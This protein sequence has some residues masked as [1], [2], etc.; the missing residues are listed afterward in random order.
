MPFRDHSRGQAIQIGVVLLLG[1]L[2]IAFSL[3]QAVVV[4]DQNQSIEFSHNQEVQGEL[5]GVRN[6]FVSTTDG[7]RSTS[8]SVGLGTQY[9]SRLLALNPS[10]PSGVL[11][12]VGTDNESVNVAI[13]YAVADGETGDFWNGTNRTY[14]TG[15]VVYR[16]GYNEYSQAPAT[17]YENSVLYNRFP[18]SNL[19]LTGQRLIDENRIS[20][21]TVNGSFYAGQ[22]GT[23]SM[24]VRPVSASPTTVT[25]TNESNETLTISVPTWLS[26][27]RW[28]K[29]LGTE[30]NVVNYTLSPVA[31]AD[32]GL[33][34]VE[35]AG[36]V[37]YE[38]QLSR[39][40]VGTGVVRPSAAYLTDVSGNGSTVPE[41]GTTTVTVQVRDALDNPKTSVATVAGTRR[42]NSSVSPN[43]TT[44]DGEGKVTHTYEAPADVSG[45]SQVADTINVSIVP[46]L[47]PENASESDFD[48]RTAR[49]VSMQVLIDNTD[50]SGT[51][52]GSA[53]EINWSFPTIETEQGIEGCFASNNTCV[54]DLGKDANDKVDFAAGTDPSTSGVFVD[55]TLNNSLGTLNPSE[56]STDSGGD[57]STE[58]KNPSVGTTNLSALTTESNDVV[59]VRV[60]DSGGGPT[61]M[62]VEADSGRQTANVT[63]SEGVYT[64]AS[65]TGDL[66]ASDFDYFDNSSGGVSGI[67][68]VSHT[69]GDSKA[70]LTLDAGTTVGDIGTDEVA[71]R[72]N[73]IYDASGNAADTTPETLR[74]TRAPDD[75][76]AT[77]GSTIT[78]SNEGSYS[79][80]VELVDDHEAGDVEVRLTDGSTTAT[81]TKSVSAET[82]GDSST[83]TV[84]V[85]GIDT[86]SLSDGSVDIEARIT[87]Y[88]GNVNPSDYTATS[89]VTK[90]T[91]PP[92]VQ[93]DDPNGGETIAG[94]STYTI[95][96]TASDSETGVSGID[97]A[98]STNG[99][100]SYTTIVTGTTDDGTYDWSVPTVNTS[101]ALIRV[102]A[103]DSVGNTATDTSD[104]TF[105]IDSTSPQITSVAEPADAVYTDGETLGFDVTYDESVTVD[106]SGGTPEIT[107]DVDGDGDTEPATYVSGSGSDTLTFEYTVQTGDNDQDGIAFDSTSIALN[108]GTIRDSAGNDADTDFSG[109]APDL[110]GILV[111][112]APPASLTI[113]APSS[114]VTRQS[115]ETLDVTY[116]YDEA[117]PDSANITLA[118]GSGNNATFDVDDS[119]YA[120]DNSGKTVTL[121]LSS[122]DSTSG[123]GLVD[124]N[125]YDITVEATDVV[126]QSNS[127]T[128]TDRL[129]IDSGQ[130]TTT[131]ASSILPYTGGQRQ[132]VT[133]VPATDIPDGD[134][135]YIVLDDPQQKTPL[136]VNYAIDFTVKRGTTY[137]SNTNSNKYDGGDRAF[138]K[139]DFETGSGLPA[140]TP[141]E[142]RLND[143]NASTPAAQTDPYDVTINRTDRAD[144]ATNTT[145][146]V[147][148]SDGDSGLSSVSLTNI[149][150]GTTVDQTISFTPDR[151]IPSGGRVY[152][153]LSLAQN[154]SGSR[155]EYNNSNGINTVSFG[156]ASLTTT[157]DSAA[158]TYKADSGAVSAGTT[159]DIEVTG[160]TAVLDNERVATFE[161]GFSRGDAD[162]T[163][164]TFQL[165]NDPSAIQFNALQGFEGNATTE[166]FTIDQVDVR[167]TKGTNNLDRIEYEV[168]D[169]N[170]AVVAS[171]TDD[172][173]GNPSRYQESNLVISADS[174][175][176]FDTT[177]TLTVTAFDQVG[178]RNNETRTDTTK[179]A[180]GANVIKLVSGSGTKSGDTNSN[181]SFTVENIADSDVTVRNV[182]V[183]D[184]DTPAISKVGNGKKIGGSYTDFGP[185]VESN[186]TGT[187]L[188]TSNQFDIGATQ[189]LTTQDT[190][191]GKAR[192]E[193]T[194]GEFRN[195]G[196]EKDP[197]S[198]VT[199]RLGFTDGTAATFT[200]SL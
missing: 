172:A 52:A 10:P 5:Q 98:Y 175:V 116:S 114:Q 113:D 47:S 11:Q 33:L 35:L 89:T 159:I 138:V 88:G 106:T 12:T 198:S 174:D 125:T 40:G 58:L 91:T 151:Q 57:V 165:R 134:S 187:L 122:P 49:N 104:S 95:E 180:T 108:G 26:E 130:F 90:D 73:Q 87:D 192:T 152:I 28:D 148:Y 169:P 135:V 142:L 111:D 97:I 102:R 103:E 173:S 24:D 143:I 118:D 149:T 19:T 56:N 154:T 109:V 31:G 2:V 119:A 45:A 200:I 92:A 1:A 60:K 112:T 7:A 81:G 196:N 69:A 191:P 46:G 171:R 44:S 178:N 167:D 107:L 63:F 9:S 128:A 160:I 195:N 75:P 85:S 71:A 161:V 101:N 78:P 30:S 131:Y 132:N 36:D 197:G 93:V 184:T 38:L 179:P 62:S 115:S 22:A 193:Y 124:G 176:K 80:D 183:V 199:I 27:T 77:S 84:T 79:V 76:T 157:A 6:A 162:T 120:G 163:N 21:V 139:L 4:P 144:S 156:D 70:T 153:D 164:T 141:V 43:D 136:Q 168:T 126:S 55:F 155:V 177:Y 146:R 189:T 51:S 65:G 186:R 37:D 158:I 121:D 86:S 72:N 74:D 42:S 96:W 29:L 123:S 48:P 185:E 3:Y 140:G 129:V 32:Y 133:F 94:G 8:V 54:Y 14:N 105:T 147:S 16:P 127:T 61:I 18:D 53:Y 110:S 188:N 15:A 150:A 117:N 39:A 194:V 145:F 68:S 17:W 13:A 99:G 23:V 182:T 34:T 20:L 50:G 64:S 59:T 170:G 82:D 25:V 67:T 181:T 166:E 190:I 137:V 66:T 83:D 41:N 100:S